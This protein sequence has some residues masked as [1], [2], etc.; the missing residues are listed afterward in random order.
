MTFKFS[1]RSEN[2]LTGVNA[3]LVALARVALSLSPVDF[4]I[5]EGLRTRERQKELVAAGKSQTMK[6]RHITGHAVDVYAY[7]AGCPGGSWDWQYYEQ[8]AKAFR[9]ASQQTGIPF[10][11]GGDWKTLKDGPHFQLPA[12]IYP[13]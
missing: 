1:K 2:N 8:I 10:E 6:S 12:N 4:G 13:D 3:D 9:R 7:P 5:T 11:W